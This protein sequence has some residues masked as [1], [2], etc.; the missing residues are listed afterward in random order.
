[1]NAFAR[2]RMTKDAVAKAGGVS[3]ERVMAKGDVE[4]LKVEEGGE[5]AGEVKKARMSSLLSEGGG[6]FSFG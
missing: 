2:K 4:V 3:P 1:M 6:S 5:E